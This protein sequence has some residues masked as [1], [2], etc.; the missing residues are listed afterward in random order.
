MTTSTQQQKE[1][2]EMMKGFGGAEGPGWGAVTLM[3][4][5]VKKL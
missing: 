1:W 2:S 5:Q 3:G 4:N